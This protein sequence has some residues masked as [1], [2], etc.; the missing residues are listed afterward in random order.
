LQLFL[1]AN[2]A[3]HFWIIVVVYAERV[4][5]VYFAGSIESKIPIF[6]IKI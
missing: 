2:V 6:I 4:V 1:S 5:V 3:V